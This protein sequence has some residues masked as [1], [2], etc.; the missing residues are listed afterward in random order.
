MSMKTTK[1]RPGAAESLRRKVCAL[2]ASVDADAGTLKEAVE[3]LIALEVPKDTAR[4]PFELHTVKVCLEKGDELPS[5][6]EENPLDD[7]DLLEEVR[8]QVF[9]LAPWEEKS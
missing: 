1:P 5:E 3:R 4:A 8:R 6:Y 7:D 2:A 9:G